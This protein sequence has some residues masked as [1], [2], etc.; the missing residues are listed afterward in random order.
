MN[1]ANP[2]NCQTLNN[3]I[4]IFSG[5][6]LISVTPPHRIFLYTQC[7]HQNQFK[8][9]LPTLKYLIQTH[10]MLRHCLQVSRTIASE[11]MWITLL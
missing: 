8:I 2:V 6:T 5:A 7:R 3:M 11:E 9:P 4:K 1:C 10:C